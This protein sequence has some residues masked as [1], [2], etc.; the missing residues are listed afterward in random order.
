MHEPVNRLFYKVVI[1]LGVP[2]QSK[3]YVGVKRSQK[4]GGIGSVTPHHVTV[5]VGRLKERRLEDHLLPLI[6]LGYRLNS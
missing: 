3:R 5:V 4:G 1:Q 2:V 6:D